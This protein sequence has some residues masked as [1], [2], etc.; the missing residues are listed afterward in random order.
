M[1]D[2]SVDFTPIPAQI[3]NRPH[4]TPYYKTSPRMSKPILATAR[5]PR[6]QADAKN[7]I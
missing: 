1:N 5:D 2:Q 6:N 4:L 7:L 3:K